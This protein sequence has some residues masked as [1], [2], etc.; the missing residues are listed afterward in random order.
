MKVFDSGI[1]HLTG[2]ATRLDR[3]IAANKVFYQGYKSSCT[4]RNELH[5]LRAHYPGGLPLPSYKIHEMFLTV[6]NTLVAQILA[7][8]RYQQAVVERMQRLGGCIACYLFHA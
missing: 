4:E 6:G 2:E 3:F 5:F 1:L 7:L 8:E